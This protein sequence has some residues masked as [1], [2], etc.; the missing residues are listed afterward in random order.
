MALYDF[1][2]IAGAGLL[3]HP[4]PPVLPVQWAI[5]KNVALAVSTGGVTRAQVRGPDRKRLTLRWERITATHKGLFEAWFASYGGGQAAFKVELPNTTLLRVRC[6]Q[7]IME[8]RETQDNKYSI[9][10]ELLEDL[11]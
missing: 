9:V 4:K 2:T 11:V 5:V 1:T 3:A 7:V 10:L 8:V 6:L